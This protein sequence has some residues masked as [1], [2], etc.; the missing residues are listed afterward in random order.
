MSEETDFKRPPLAIS[1]VIPAFNEADVIK[2]AIAEASESLARLTDDYEVIVVDDGSRDETSG[3]IQ[4]AVD[5][6]PRI[7]LIR[8]PQNRGYGASLRTGFA[9]ATGQLVAFTDADCQFNLNE[10]DRFILLAESY[11]IVCGYR[12]DR[13]DSK[14]RCLYSRVYN[15]I[16]RTLLGI[17]VRDI[18]CALKLFHRRVSQ[19]LTI[20][21][22]GFLVNSELLTQARQ[23]GYSLVE[24]GV[25]HR[26]RL[27]GQS[28]V[29]IRHIP[30]VL[31]SLLRYWWN[32]V[33]FP[34]ETNSQVVEQPA[35]RVW[36]WPVLALLVIAAV[37]VLTNLSYPLIDRDE[38]RY[39]EIPREM[40]VT[41]DWVIPQLNFLPYYDKPPLLYWSCAVSYRVLGVH[42]WA[43]RL[44]PALAALLALVTTIWFASRWFG[45]RAGLWSGISLSLT[46]GFL[47]CSRYL[48]IDGLFTA[49][50]TLSWMMAY[51]SLRSCRFR[52]GWWYASAACCG[53]AIL[54][55][56]PVAW[57]LWLPPV[58]GYVWLTDLKSRPGPRDFA[59]WIAASALVAAP[60]FAM[61]AVRDP[62]FLAEFLLTHHVQRFAGAFHE[63]PLWYF[64]P[65]LL[66]AGHPWSSLTIPL[67]QFL[68]SS[69]RN[70]SRRR[71]QALGI[72]MLWSAWC[73]TFFTLSRCKLPTYLLPMAPGIAMIVG[74]YMDQ[75]LADS[76]ERNESLA[77]KWSPRIAISITA[78]AAIGFLVYEWFTDPGSSVL[79]I[80]WTL[81]WT[82]VLI[83]TVAVMRHFRSS[84][85]AWTATVCTT[86]LLGFMLMHQL[87][88]TYS[89]GQ[90]LLGE[91]LALR[92]SVGQAD[93][94]V[95][96]SREFSEV[97]YYLNRNTMEHWNGIENANLQRY[98]DRYS[99]AVLV[100]PDELP[101]GSLRDQ[102]PEAAR[103]RLI[104]RRDSGKVVEVR[105]PTRDSAKSVANTHAIDRH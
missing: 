8:H 66:L 17:N 12:I 77:R 58:A 21:G 70:F 57:A 6:D 64:V 76:S 52:R 97:P 85:S 46:A 89:R 20:A 51:E 45:R 63:R 23:K 68:F 95:S 19:E 39:A 74:V 98:F 84:G 42:P 4:Q 26:A 29:S 67:S 59:F 5:H 30:C 69:N 91:N 102:L 80:A 41:G 62:H 55:K 16:A 25:T 103:I 56:G 49:L 40:L 87:L 71:P 15:L 73:F 79:V 54:A 104:A 100:L 1:L 10:L 3:L 78:T 60:W 86:A 2:E 99:H 37:F 11:D 47:F 36:S 53:L 82:M 32:Q 31:S 75:L 88:P 72:A 81:L 14:L 44:V 83:M 7:R 61:V 9:A 65:V 50:V 27:G 35:R 34:C 22:D 93:Q 43:A 28:S 18:D 101:I 96:I 33:Q 24:V 92:A 38:T 13:K 48:L 105:V 94:V 90:S